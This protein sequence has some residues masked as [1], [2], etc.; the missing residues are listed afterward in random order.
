MSDKPKSD[1]TP[2]R[3]RRLAGLKRQMRGLSPFSG[4]NQPSRVALF[5]RELNRPTQPFPHPW[6]YQDP[7]R[8]LESCY[9][10]AEEIEGTGRHNRYLD[11]FGFTP[12]LITRDPGMIRA[13]MLATGDGP[14]Q[15]DRDTLPFVGIAKATGRNTLLSSNGALWRRQRKLAANPFGKTR[16]FQLERFQEFEETFRETVAARIDALR[17]RLQGRS[18]T[19]AMI[20]LEPE[21]KLIML[22][23]LTN[24]FFGAEIS[25]DELRG[26]Y[27]PAMERIIE[28]IVRDTV[29]GQLPGVGWA[30]SLLRAKDRTFKEDNAVFERLT[31]RVVDGRKHGRAQWSHFKADLPDSA[32]RE[33]LK[34]FLAGALEAT[35]SYACW[36]I[37]HLARNL[38][39]QAKTFECVKNISA[40][41]PDNL[42]SAEYLG[43]VLNETLRLTPSLYFLPRQG[44]AD[45]WVETTDGRKMFIPKG[46][47]ILLDIWHAN[48]HED[49]WGV[50]AT[51]HPAL[52][53]V[54][55]RWAEMEA[56]G[57]TAKDRMH[58]G[59]GHG[60]RICPGQHLGQLEAALVVGGFVKLFTFKSPSAGYSTIAGVSTKPGDGT[61]VQLELR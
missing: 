10:G 54:P 23:M 36:A 60:A 33:N 41:T 56:R 39:A 17:R 16:I 14:G 9:C 47:H 30:I 51:G 31:D 27:M 52:K 6:N 26:V 44:T 24:N 11:V 2:T 45:V 43:H 35:T 40:Y 20:R 48:R 57:E 42:R 15:F 1:W 37:S 5:A 59:F 8:I 29:Y 3:Y 19:T 13:I 21:V 28:H 12:F 4:D 50:N 7:I 55:E 61:L 34:V 58:F 53:F 38:D 46:I 49:H 22:E 18:E 25:H 32:L